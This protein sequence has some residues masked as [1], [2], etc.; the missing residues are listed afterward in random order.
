MK[1]SWFFQ[2]IVVIIAILLTI[3]FIVACK[4]TPTE[5]IVT[6][7]P[8]QIG[9]SPIPMISPIFFVPISSPSST[10]DDMHD[11]SEPTSTS[12]PTATPVPTSTPMSASRVYYGQTNDPAFRMRLSKGE[13]Y[14]LA[15]SPSGDRLAI[16]SSI[17][18]QLLQSNTFREIWSGFTKGR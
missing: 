11:N 12:T 13:F 2:G 9:A 17:G 7:I 8:S 3:I 1:N 16:A 5:V 15:I 14:S 4:S 10:P 6:G 18:V